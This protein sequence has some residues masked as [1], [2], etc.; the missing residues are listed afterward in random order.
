MKFWCASIKLQKF[1]LLFLYFPSYPHI[2]C[3]AEIK[4]SVGW[5]DCPHFPANFGFTEKLFWVEY[6][7]AVIIKVL[8]QGPFTKTTSIV[9]LIVFELLQIKCVE[10]HSPCGGAALC[11]KQGDRPHLQILAPRATCHVQ[12]FAPGVTGCTETFKILV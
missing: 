4:Y 11:T 9:S 6:S 3:F 12:I 5:G 8:H 10:G 7:Y 1:C 2:C